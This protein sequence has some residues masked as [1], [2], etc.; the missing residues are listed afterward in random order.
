M[1]NFVF[2]FV[3]N[4]MKISCCVFYTIEL[5]LY[6]YILSGSPEWSS[7]LEWTDV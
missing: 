4:P 5:A 2:N 7:V 1:S 3:Y 6:F